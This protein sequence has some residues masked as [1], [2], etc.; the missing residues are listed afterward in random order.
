MT[1][2]VI[3]YLILGL[4]DKLGSVGA[5]RDHIDGKKAEG[6]SFNQILDELEAERNEAAKEAH[7]AVEEMPDDE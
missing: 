1:P 5:A 3:A 7:D 2:E 6:K 4:V